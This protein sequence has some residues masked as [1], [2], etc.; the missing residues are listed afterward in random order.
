M[1]AENET[2]VHH[3]KVAASHDESS[4]DRVEKA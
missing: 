3:D 2:F 4:V 1:I